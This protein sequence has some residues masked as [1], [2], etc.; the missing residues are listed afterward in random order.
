MSGHVRRALAIAVTGIVVAGLGIAG[1]TAASAADREKV[2]SVDCGSDCTDIEYIES[3]GNDYLAPARAIGSDV[4]TCPGAE[5]STATATQE[6]ITEKAWSFSIGGE[7]NVE[8]LG[9]IGAA[10][11]GAFGRG[12]AESVANL[13]GFEEPIPA[14]HIGHM[15]FSQRMYHSEGVMNWTEQFFDEFH[16]SADFTADVTSE[17]PMTL[18][19]GDPDGVYDVDSRLMNADEL[20][21]F[22]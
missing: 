14:G 13:T 11:T 16:S 17:T 10:V 7:F 1:I 9:G 15:T 18:D 6:H 21:R 12:V 19:N 8:F 2:D 4:K 5:P 3:A 20:A 22:C